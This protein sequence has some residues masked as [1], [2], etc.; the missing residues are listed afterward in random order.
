MTH[1]R[2]VSIIAGAAVLLAASLGS[3]ARRDSAGAMAKAAAASEETNQIVPVVKA[4]RTG[5]TGDITLTAEFEPFQEVDVMSKVAGYLKEIKVDIGDRVQEGQLLATLEIPEM[6]DDLTKAAA[7]ID[8]AEADAVTARDELQRAESAHNIAQLYAGRI[9][10]VAKSEP[11][12]VPQ[13]ELDEVHSRDLQSEAQV[14]AAKS[15]IHSNEERA[16]VAR[17]EEAHVKTLLKYTQITAPFTGV[18]TKRY[19][20]TG[21]MI[22]AGTASQSQ[23][24]PIVRL[25]QNNLLRLVLPVPESAAPR[26]RVGETVDVR[27]PS[28]NRTFPGRVAR[29]T[30]KVQE[31]TRTMDTEV[32]VP[33]PSLTLLP[34]LY[35]EVDLRLDQHDN[36]LAVPLDAV[37]RTGDTA[38]VYTVQEPG[39]IHIVPVTLGLESSQ[40]VEIRSGL[41]EGEQVV[42]GRLAG[43]KEG[44]RV[45]AEPATFE[46]PEKPGK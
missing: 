44:Q 37:E 13:Q 14:A 40:R 3:C 45:H 31:S 34:G 30:G 27:V 8:Q 36:V 46:G 4:G 2:S 24:M 21:S 15:A 17:A 10:N 32:D 22:Q 6:A 25:S 1:A 39:V 26:I 42:V 5:L 43:L 9:E 16:R 35:A 11:G 7:T 41:Q 29:S 23:A 33:N 38:R 20:N 18:V 12:L 28:M 19:A